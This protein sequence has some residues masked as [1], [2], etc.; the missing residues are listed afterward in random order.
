MSSD[1][2][3][4]LLHAISAMAIR[5]PAQ[6]LASLFSLPLDDLHA[7]LTLLATYSRHGRQWPLYSP[8]PSSDARA[9]VGANRCLHAHNAM[10]AFY[11]SLVGHC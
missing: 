2:A 10:L 6:V 7:V 8:P 4:G 11:A 3:Q 1:Q 9:L 5:I